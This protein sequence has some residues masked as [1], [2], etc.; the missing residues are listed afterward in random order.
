MDF[1][2]R[3][4]ALAAPLAAIDFKEECCTG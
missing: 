1:A 2:I 3:Y 4:H